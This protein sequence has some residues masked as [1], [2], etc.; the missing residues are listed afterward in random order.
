MKRWQWWACFLAATFLLSKVFECSRA[1]TSGSAEANVP[2][3]VIWLLAL[4]L[5]FMLLA[6]DAYIK[7][8]RLGKIPKPNAF[9]EFLVKRFASFDPNLLKGL[10][11]DASH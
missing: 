7:D 4:V 10:T 3:L 8:K 6:M 11:T 9:M 1:V 5:T 2:M